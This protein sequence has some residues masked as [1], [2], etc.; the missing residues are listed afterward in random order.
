MRASF[1]RVQ[2]RR[3]GGSR[4]S[5]FWARRCHSAGA[6]VRLVEEGVFE[7][8]GCILEMAD[9]DDGV[10]EAILDGESMAGFVKHTFLD[11]SNDIADPIEA[12]TFLL[13]TIPRL[14]YYKTNKKPRPVAAG[15]AT[16]S[17]QWDAQ[18]IGL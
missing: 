17:A 8:D 1:L 4:R 7:S 3:Q 15:E 11:D 5:N 13:V 18:A 16:A 12:K 9:G 6:Q 2:A 14:K 10:D